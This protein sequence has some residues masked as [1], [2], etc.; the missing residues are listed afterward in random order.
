M[1]ARTWNGWTSTA[2]ADAYEQLLLSEVGPGILARDIAGFLEIQV[3]RRPVG[4]DEVEF[5]TIMWFESIEAVKAFAGEDHER[6]VVPAAAQALL[7]RF[8]Q[9]SRHAEV[10]ARMGG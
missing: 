8:D 10:R 2:D 3:L 4:D 6:A 1:I 7:S 9:R 5:T